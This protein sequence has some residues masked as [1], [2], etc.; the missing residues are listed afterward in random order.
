M[1]ILWLT[2]VLVRVLDE[3]IIHGTANKKQQVSF[4]IQL[5]MS[6]VLCFFIRPNSFLVYLIAAPVLTLLFFFRKKWKLLATISISVV[7]VLLI[8][9]LLDYKAVTHMYTA[10]VRYQALISDI[11]GTYYGGG[12]LSE[13]TQNALM[14]YIPKLD[15]PEVRDGF[16]PNWLVNKN[17][18]LSELAFGE[19][20]S[21]YADSF[22][23][24]PL[25]MI[26][27]MSYRC[28]VYWAIDPDPKGYP[29]LVNYTSIYNPFTNTYS[30]YVSEI[31]VYRQE[32][33]LTRIMDSY[34]V[35]MAKSIPA[36]FVW[37]FGFWTALM[38]ISA[39]TLILQKKYIWLLA[40]LP[41]FT[42]L[43]TLLLATGWADYRYGLPV[44]FVGMF[45]PLTF[46]LQGRK[47]KDAE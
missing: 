47:A 8:N 2:Y 23:H 42:Y 22:I 12:K 15:E 41:V 37:R 10:K 5:C 29:G 11:Q 32:N 3:V 38:I 17:Y 40:Y 20:I 25:K 21:M 16:T 35:P 28:S 1:S 4:Y 6:F 34:M 19:F 30:S 14:K 9:N 13:Q 24:N 18:D 45:L 46:I 36:I 26:R 27:S 33:I 31:G 43:V 44:F 39:M 7:M